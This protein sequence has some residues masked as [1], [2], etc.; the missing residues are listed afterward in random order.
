MNSTVSKL[1]RFMTDIM[2]VAGEKHWI[3]PFNSI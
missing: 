2:D 3:W 1:V